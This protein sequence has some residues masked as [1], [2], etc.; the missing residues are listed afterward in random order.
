VLGKHSG[1]H[2]LRQ[3]V[4]TLGFELDEPELNRL[5]DEF[6]ALAENKRELSDSDIETLVLRASER[7]RA[8]GSV[9]EISA[10]EMNVGT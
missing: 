5:F 8:G 3:R 9:G 6:K 10:A 7:S 2:A 4:K 1:R